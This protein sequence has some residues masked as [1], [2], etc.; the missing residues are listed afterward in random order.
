[1][2]K[3]IEVEVDEDEV[4][5]GFTIQERLYDLWIRDFLDSLADKGVEVLQM[6]APAE[7]KPGHPYSEGYTQRH[8]DRSGV[9]KVLGEDGIVGYE[10]VI[11]VKAGTSMHPLYADQGTGVY[12]YTGDVIR[13]RSGRLMYFY[14]TRLGTIISTYEVR[15]QRPQRF[16][17]ETWRD[18]GIYADLR[19]AFGV[20]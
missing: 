11:G 18:L 16:L 15:G 17:Y 3:W 19:L 10:A 20:F 14:G 12:S 4:M 7:G 13:S 9:H 8:I 2:S 6:H 1:M 5:H